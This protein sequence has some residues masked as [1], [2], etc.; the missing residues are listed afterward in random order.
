[1]ISIRKL[2]LALTLPAS[3]ATAQTAASQPPAAAAA[4]PAQVTVEQTA[5]P[6]IVG[7]LM[8]EISGIRPDQAQAAAATLFGAAKTRLPAADFAKVAAAVPN[9]DGL[10]K[11]APAPKGGLGNSL[12][13]AG[14]LSKLG[15]KPDQILKVTPAL[16]KVMQ[17]KA[18]AEVAGLLAGALK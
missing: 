18:G 12:A 13:I 16:V 4:A 6:E 7:A 11:A 17:S 5:S 10:L 14:A 9:M 2:A 8:N 15:L 3:L 1:M